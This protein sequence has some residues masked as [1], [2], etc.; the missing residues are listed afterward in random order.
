MSKQWNEGDHWHSEE[1]LQKQEEG[2][3]GCISW[4][5]TMNESLH[6]EWAENKKEKRRGEKNDQEGK[7]HTSQ[8][9]E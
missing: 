3:E 5:F 8:R 1:A 6:P 9:G 7:N 4:G 2:E